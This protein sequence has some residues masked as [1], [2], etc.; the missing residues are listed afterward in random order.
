MSDIFCGEIHVSGDL[1]IYEEGEMMGSTGMN[2][3]KNSSEFEGS[4]LKCE[5]NLWQSV[6]IQGIKDF[7]QKAKSIEDHQQRDA[8]AWFKAK[9]DEPNSF[10][11]VCDIL[12]LNADRARAKVFGL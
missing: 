4:E 6:L 11:W 8:E 7:E 3:W 5:L 2:T 9:S 12:G 10:I 1:E